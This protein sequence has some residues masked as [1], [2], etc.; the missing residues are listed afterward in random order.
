MANPI[1]PDDSALR[2]V[3]YRLYRDF[4]DRAEKKRRWSLADDVPWHQ[5]NRAPDPAI[6]YVVESF[7]AVELYLPD[8]IAKALPLVR[9]NKGWAWFH[10]NE[11]AAWPIRV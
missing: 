11:T 7:C 1:Q 5:V 10:A 4:F 2:I 6:A 8:Y 9:A 3:M